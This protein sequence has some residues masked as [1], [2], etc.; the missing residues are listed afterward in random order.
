[1][2]LILLS[3][4]HAVRTLFARYGVEKRLTFETISR[5]KLGPEGLSESP[6]QMTPQAC[7]IADGRYLGK[8]PH[9]IAQGLRPKRPH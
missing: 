1:M 6:G 4:D 7:P 3:S 9:K 2:C 5:G 8:K